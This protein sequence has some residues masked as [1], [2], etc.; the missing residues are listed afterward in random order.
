M[1]S[2]RQAMALSFTSQ[3]LVLLVNIGSTIVIARL[4]TPE[5]V[6]IYSIGAAFVALGQV[7]RDFGSGQY[8]IQEKSL[9][10]DRI[11][12]AFTVTLGFGWITALIVL[13][14]APIAARFYGQPGVED[15][16]HLLALNFALLPFGSI[17]MAYL[18]RDMAF[19]KTV[20]ISFTGTLLGA[21]TAIGCAYNG[22]SYMS[23]AWGALAGTSGTVVMAALFRPKVLPVLP[24]LRQLRHVLKFSGQM[25]A[26]TILAQ[27]GKSAPELIIGK[28]QGAAGVGLYSRGRGIIDLFQMLV[29]RGLNPV[30]M[31]LFARQDRAGKAL[32]PPY[33]YGISCIT[34]LAWGFYAGLGALAPEFVVVVFGDHWAPA[35]PLVEIWCGAAVISLSVQT[36]GN[37]LIAT[38]NISALLRRQVLM[39]PVGIILVL[40]GANISLEALAWLGLLS[41]SLWVA[42]LLPKTMS[43]AR[44]SLRDYLRAILPSA[45]PALATLATAYATKYWLK[46]VVGVGDVTVLAVATVV[47]ALTWLLVLYAIRHPL[48][49]EVDRA[50]R[51]LIGRLRRRNNDKSV[52]KD[53]DTDHDDPHA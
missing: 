48:T 43:V 39:L 15:V 14:L 3:Y 2:A 32:G 21:I 4:L 47:G 6:G 18:Q 23:M 24:G 9:T 17:T 40:I 20:T 7:L 26:S 46:Q 22:L 53:S 44:F 30:L 36:A 50:V 28:L 34:A 49:Q 37:V 16:L 19:H 52:E 25:S 11:R 13:L 51:M 45:P 10:P 38:G 33:L 31:P 41:S 8:I 29:L 12:A 5:E 35:V 42:L 1:I 27:V